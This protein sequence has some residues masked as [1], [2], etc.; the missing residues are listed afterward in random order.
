MEFFGRRC[1][2]QPVV[3]AHKALV[4]RLSVA[5]LQSRRELEHGGFQGVPPREDCARMRSSSVGS[6]SGHLSA[7]RSSTARALSSP[8]SPSLYSRSSLLIATVLST[9]VPH[10]VAISV[11]SRSSPVIVPETGWLESKGAIAELRQNRKGC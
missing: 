2:T 8:S 4:P 5:P 7:R 1:G 3:Q 11:S 9:Q 10:H 6:T